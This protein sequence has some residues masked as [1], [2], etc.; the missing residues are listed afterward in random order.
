[1]TT[2]VIFYR[3]FNGNTPIV[4]W[5]ISDRLLTHI[6]KFSRFTLWNY[7]VHA[8]YQTIIKAFHYTLIDLPVDYKFPYSQRYQHCSGI[9]KFFETLPPHKP[10]PVINE[11]THPEFYI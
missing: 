9:C 2:T 11:S 6:K 10:L 1:M 8:H 3:T 7:R 5:V 4:D